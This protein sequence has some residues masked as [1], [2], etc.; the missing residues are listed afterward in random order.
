MPHYSIVNKILIIITQHMFGLEKLFGPKTDF[1]SLVNSGA[2]IIDVRSAAEFVTGQIAGSKNI[3]VD[4]M[5]N[6]IK[7]LKQL[8]RPVIT[9][10]RSGGRS[11]MAS[12]ILNAAGIE[13]YNGGAGTL[14]QKKLL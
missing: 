4:L 8:K 12:R 10:C 2:V 1:K 13:S 3:N 6:R 7:G 9:C 11:T 5:S 14:L